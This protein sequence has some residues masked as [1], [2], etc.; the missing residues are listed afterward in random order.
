M[1]VKGLDVMARDGQVSHSEMDLRSPSAIKHPSER[2]HETKS[3]RHQKSV[4]TISVIA[5]NR[6]HVIQNFFNEKKLSVSLLMLA[7]PNYDTKNN[8]YDG[9]L[10]FLKFQ[11]KAI[12]ITGG[13]ITVNLYLTTF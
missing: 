13:D 2:I 7:L 9:L 11:V 8:Y 4:T 5:T 10:L 1:G 3:R 12:K 6:T